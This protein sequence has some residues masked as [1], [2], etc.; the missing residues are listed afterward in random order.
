VRIIETRDK[1]IPSG[2]IGQKAWENKHVISSWEQQYGPTQWRDTV[3]NPRFWL[4]V[5]SSLLSH[6]GGTDVAR[7]VYGVVSFSA[8]TT[9][10]QSN[11][12]VTLYDMN[13]TPPSGAT[14]SG[15][16][17]GRPHR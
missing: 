13:A 6:N 8:R 9:L 15:R 17:A 4:A 7:A 14:G 3:R 12:L 1:N 2:R 10:D 11:R 16:P 5:D